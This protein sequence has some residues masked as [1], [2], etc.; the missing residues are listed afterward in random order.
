MGA[1]IEDGSLS[2]QA[3]AHPLKLINEVVF[4]KGRT[5]AISQSFY[6]AFWPCMDNRSS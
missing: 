4:T 2:C 5:A 3:K 1:P 6:N